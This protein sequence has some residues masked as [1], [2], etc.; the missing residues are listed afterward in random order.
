MKATN[1]ER[2]ALVD[3]LATLLYIPSYDPATMVTAADL[4]ARMGDGYTKEI[5]RTELDKLV[6][7]GT[8]KKIEVRFPNGRKG[9]SYVERE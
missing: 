1:E 3:R 2:Q 8:L 6:K 5:A 7:A 9:Y 4:A